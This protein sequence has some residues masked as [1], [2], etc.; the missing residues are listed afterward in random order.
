MRGG[1]AVYVDSVA[2]QAHAIEQHAFD[3]VDVVDAGEERVLARI[4]VDAD[5]ERMV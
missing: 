5:Q 3:R 2:R 4:G 1:Q